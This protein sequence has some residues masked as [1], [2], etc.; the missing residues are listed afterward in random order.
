MI[1]PSELRKNYDDNKQDYLAQYLLIAIEQVEELRATNAALLKAL[2]E[3]AVTAERDN[4]ELDFNSDATEMLSAE[5][6]RVIADKHEGKT[7]AMLQAY[8]DIL[9]GKLR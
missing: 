5:D 7:K 1:K 3:I 2:E 4:V 9:D 6:A 8:A